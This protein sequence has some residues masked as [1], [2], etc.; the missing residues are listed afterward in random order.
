M[1][2]FIPHSRPR[3]TTED[4]EAVRSALQLGRFAQGAE[5]EALEQELCARF[6]HAH[7]VVV[8]SGS[9]ALLLSLLALG[10]KAGDTVACPSYTC[11]CLYSAVA[12]AGATVRC[13][14][15]QHGDV[16]MAAPAGAARRDVAAAIVPH[17]FGFEADVRAWTGGGIPCVEDCAQAAGGTATGGD[18]MGRRGDIAIL[19]FYA[20]KLLPAGEGGACLTNDPQAADTIRRLR[21]SDEQHLSPQAFNFKMTDISAALARVKLR[22]LDEN[23]A[24]RRC[25]A[26]RYDNAFGAFSFRVRHGLRQPVCFRYLLEVAPGQTGT[27]IARARAAGIDC[28]LPVWRPLHQSLGADCPQ[29]EIRQQTLISVPVYASL[30]ESEIER[31]INEISHIIGTCV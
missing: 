10:I 21:N 23:I 17:M 12:Y 19:S 7:A 22:Q 9:S 2:T 5:V 14:D 16:G 29:A 1:D 4:L 3:A 15:C 11:Q 30:S 18:R 24:I 31:I 25:I 6:G 28:R 8:S 27:V 13:I 26:E 20:T